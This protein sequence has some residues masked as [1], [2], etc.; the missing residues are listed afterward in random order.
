MQRGRTPTEGTIYVVISKAAG[1]LNLVVSCECLSARTKGSK[2]LRDSCTHTTRHKIQ[3]SS[4]NSK[5]VVKN[6]DSR[7]KNTESDRVEARKRQGLAV[8]P[9]CWCPEMAIPPHLRAQILKMTPLTA[10][11]SVSD[12][13]ERLS[14]ASNNVSESPIVLSSTLWLHSFGFPG[15][16]VTPR[17]GFKTLP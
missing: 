5:R 14:F 17:M 8:S 15:N 1:L 11:L 9:R 6:S 16:S 7:V 12:S 3:S 13:A 10:P 2:R 4:N